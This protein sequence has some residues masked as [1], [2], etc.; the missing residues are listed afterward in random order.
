MNNSFIAILEARIGRGKTFTQ[1]RAA[2]IVKVSQP[3][4]GRWKRGKG[5][6]NAE[7]LAALADMFHLT[8]EEMLGRT[9]VDYAQMN[10]VSAPSISKEVLAK[11]R[12]QVQ[13][14]QTQLNAMSETLN[15]LGQ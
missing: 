3:T 9:G 6:P 8:T 15:E 1:A 2:R 12:R 13:N 11:L 14:M 4:I 5:M 10:E 7:Q